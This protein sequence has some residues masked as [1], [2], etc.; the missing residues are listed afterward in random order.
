MSIDP[1]SDDE[2]D[3]SHPKI[4]DHSFASA[5]ATDSSM[6]DEIT[7]I[8]AMAPAPAPMEDEAVMPME[9]VAEE[10]EA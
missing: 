6:S 7:T 10:P 2:L 8:A 4:L 3:T 9:A 1:T 5:G